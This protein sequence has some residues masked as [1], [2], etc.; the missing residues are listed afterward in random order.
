MKDLQLRGRIVVRTLKLVKFHVVVW[1][2]RQYS[3]CRQ[4]E[5]G[6]HGENHSH[7][8]NWEIPKTYFENIQRGFFVYKAM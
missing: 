6:A 2:T 8:P 3:K 7:T 4:N 5:T 1:Q